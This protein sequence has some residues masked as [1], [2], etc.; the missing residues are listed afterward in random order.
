MNY[1]LPLLPYSFDALEEVIDSKTMEIHY[2]KHH[3]GYIT[4]L[5][6]ALELYPEYASINIISL[7]Q[8]LETL[9]KEIQE[10][11]RNQGGGHSNHSLFWNM[12]T[13]DVN[14]RTI[15]QILLNDINETFGEFEN[16]KKIFSENALK[17]F[18]SGWSWL[19][20]NPK[21]KKLSLISTANQDS[22]Y[23]TGFVPLLGIDVWEH[24]YYLRYTNRR[25]DYINAWFSIVNWDYVA[26]QY[27]SVIK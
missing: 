13:P 27:E 1:T 3:N 12:M 20:I 22:P 6:K 14:K 9:P 24:A 5:N 15:P 21:T 23:I 7:L 18:G 25:A 26:Q 11:V 2:T 8:Q 4:A 16:F 19:V 17:R 10:T